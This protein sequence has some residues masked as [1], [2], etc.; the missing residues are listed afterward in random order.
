[1][2]PGDVQHALEQLV[3]GT[4]VRITPVP[5][6]HAPAP[7]IKLTSAILGPIEA[8]SAELWP[9]VPVVPA[10]EPGASDAVY[11]APAGIPVLG[12]SGLF[13]DPDGGRMHGLD[14]RLPVQSV[15]EGREFLFRLV[16]RYASE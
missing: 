1:V 11:I 16:K 8:V 3:R 9:G 2:A 5:T 10:L 12:V 15:V 6:G 4:G 14:E 13:V 7:P